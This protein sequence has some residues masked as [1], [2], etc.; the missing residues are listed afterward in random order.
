VTLLV[1]HITKVNKP[2]VWKKLVEAVQGYKSS[3]T[4]IN[5][6]GRLSNWQTR[7]PGSKIKVANLP[8]VGNP[9]RPSSTSN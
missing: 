6:A 8:K 2:V 5:L 7:I 4:K 3:S 9:P 1:A